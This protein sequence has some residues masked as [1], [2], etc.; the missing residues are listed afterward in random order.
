MSKMLTEDTFVDMEVK[1]AVQSLLLPGRLHLKQPTGQEE[2]M[3]LLATWSIQLSS[4][5]SAT[6]YPANDY[7]RTA[8]NSQTTK[9]ALKRNKLR[10]QAVKVVVPKLSRNSVKIKKVEEP[11]KVSTKTQK[12]EAKKTAKKTASKKAAKK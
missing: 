9:E 10:Q 1:Q 4:E 8:A 7:L 6:L 5:L 3:A 2:F 12:A 11:A